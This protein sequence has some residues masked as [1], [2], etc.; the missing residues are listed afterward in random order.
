[1]Q[2]AAYAVQKVIDTIAK[3]SSAAS[4]RVV[5]LIHSRVLTIAIDRTVIIVDTAMIMGY[6]DEAS[7]SGEALRIQ[8][9]IVV[10]ER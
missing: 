3:W 10:V 5:C 6:C 8:T 4:P 2:M 7:T 9:I 1:M